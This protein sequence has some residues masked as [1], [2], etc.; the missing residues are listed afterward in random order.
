MST[1]TWRNV[2]APDFRGSMEGYRTAAQLLSNATGDLSRGLGTF[3]DAP[4]RAQALELERANAMIN[5][6]SKQQKLT[7]DQYSFGRTQEN[8]AAQDAA[9]DPLARM[10][11][12][13]QRGDFAEQNRIAQ[14]NLP[15]LAKMTP[16]ALTGALGTSNTLT[17]NNVS[18]RKSTF[19][20]G[21]DIRDDATRQMTETGTRG[22]MEN[23]VDSVTAR[24]YVDGLDVPAPVKNN[25]MAQVNKMYPGTYGALNANDASGLGGPG[26]GPTVG[27]SNVSGSIA[28]A[29]GVS[30]SGNADPF[31]TIVGNGR[32]G[33]PSKPVTDM[34]IGETIDFGTN[35][36]IPATRG[37]AQLGL[38]P[39]MGT[40][41]V[42]AFQITRDTLR[43]F[44]P[45]VFG[46][47]WQN[48]KM[49]AENQDKLG[50][51]IFE[52]SKNGNLKDRWA[53]LPNTTP[54]AY[55]D[56]P[57]SQMRSII[58]KAEVGSDLKTQVKRAAIDTNEANTNVAFRAAEN[59]GATATERIA[60]AAGKDM[61]AA[62]AADDLRKGDFTGTSRLFLVENINKIRNDSKVDGIPTLNN[63]QA[64]E[65]L[66]D[67]ITNS[68]RSFWSPKMLIRQLTPGTTSNLAGGIRLDD[69]KVADTVKAAREG[70]LPTTLLANQA[71]KAVASTLTTAQQ[72]YSSAASALDQLETRIANG[73]PQLASELPRYR[74]QVRLAKAAVD[75]ALEKQ[76]QDPSYRSVASR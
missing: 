21:T 36:L 54:G 56:V 7:E 68:D 23:A 64:A 11:I 33:S 13:A 35:T 67:S 5:N 20:L 27:G 42:G 9:R 70:K 3:A 14:E 45:K 19:G 41:A 28:S 40:S 74:E 1:L 15:L 76:R 22:L 58:A 32:F 39:G 73:N 48:Q 8:N 49:T 71:T 57:W 12:A 34:T 53:A 60:Q 69:A 52:Q 24:R 66:R 25:L 72:T 26:L 62:E 46:S 51:A 50:Q 17:G 44:G 4:M 6:A 47:D 75:A 16:D 55:K 10:Q 2:D 37:N 63:A 43:E 30:G 59:T 29:A 61:T 38:A 31:N 18:N 65:V